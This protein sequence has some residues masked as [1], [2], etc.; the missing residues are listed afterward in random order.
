M[1]MNLPSHVV[2]QRRDGRREVLLHRAMAVISD[3]KIEIKSSRGTVILPLIG[4][5][6]AAG[7]I[8]WLAT[9]GF[10]LPFWLLIALLLFCM[11]LVPLSVMS[12]ISAIVGADV[13][14]DKAKGSATWQQGY[15]G[16]GIGTKELVPFRKIAHLEVTIEGDKPDR[17]HEQTDDV[18]QFALILVKVSGKRLTL[19]QVPVP[20]YGQTDGMD[21]TLA[22]GN[23][24]A[25]LTGSTVK[26]PEGWELV[27]IDTA[28]G[29]AP[30]TTG[31]G[32]GRKRRKTNQHT[33]RH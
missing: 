22:V 12:L 17:W 19:A 21:R 26:L 13:V 3:N 5:A 7:I 4:I 11:A 9:A 23:A 28:T 16:M 24:I 14:I 8:L 1:E 6:L 10:S 18:R 20:A 15:L 32:G 27:E 25:A 30:V 33:N 29:E 31:P 2:I